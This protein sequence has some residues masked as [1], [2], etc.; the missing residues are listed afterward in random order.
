MGDSWYEGV[1][2]SLFWDFTLIVL[3]RKERILK[4]DSESKEKL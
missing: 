4:I 3:V 2:V 1:W